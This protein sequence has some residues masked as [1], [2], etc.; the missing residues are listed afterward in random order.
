MRPDEL[1]TRADLEAANRRLLEKIRELLDGQAK[2][3]PL[4]T[5]AEAA[6][7]LGISTRTLQRLVSDEELPAARIGSGFRFRRADLEAFT[8]R[9][10]RDAG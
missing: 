5:S 1:V 2:P 3:E 9:R 8:A 6:E 7:V 10:F 4:L